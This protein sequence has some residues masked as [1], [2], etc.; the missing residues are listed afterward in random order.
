MGYIAIIC[1]FLVIACGGGGEEA[2]VVAAPATSAI[3]YPAPF[4][5][6]TVSEITIKGESH[7]AVFPCDL[8][9]VTCEN[10][11]VGGS[12]IEWLLENPDDR[13]LKTVI[14]FL[15]WNTLINN[16]VSFTVD[17]FTL[18]L[19]GIDS[20]KKYVC[21]LPVVAPAHRS[22]VIE[23]NARIKKLVG[24]DYYID[25]LSIVADANGD[26][27]PEMTSDGTH[28][29]HQAYVLLVKEIK[30]RIEDL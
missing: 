28:L 20:P 6:V 12:T 1:V 11:G 29:S 15:G 27:I 13:P 10:D 9:S 23:Y 30:K 14:I 8:F 17:K 25:T 16:T 21:G 26:W 19:W 2:P 22:K 4:Q 18:F 3:I 7:A 24:E 5:S